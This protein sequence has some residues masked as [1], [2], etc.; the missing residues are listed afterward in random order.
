MVVDQ[1]PKKN[2][3]NIYGYRDNIQLAGEKL[4]KTVSGNK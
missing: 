2:H 1:K 4:Q 3:S